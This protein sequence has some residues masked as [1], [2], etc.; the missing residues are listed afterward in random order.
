MTKRRVFHA[1]A[2]PLTLAPRDS[3]VVVIADVADLVINL[4]KAQRDARGNRI[5]VVVETL[6]TTTGCSL[7]PASIDKIQGSSITAADDKDIVNTAATDAVGDVMTIVCDGEDGWW[8][9]DSTGT[10]ARET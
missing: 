10:W 2:T 9:V 8:I 1:T 4:P 5:T 6:S 3:D 7:S